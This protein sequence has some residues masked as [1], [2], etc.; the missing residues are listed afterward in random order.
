MEFDAIADTSPFT[1]RGLLGKFKVIGAKWEIWHFSTIASSDNESG[2]GNSQRL[3]SELKPM[4]ERV[5]PSEIKDMSSLLQRDL[6]DSRVA[7]ELIP[8]LLQNQSHIGFFPAILCALMP[9]QFLSSETEGSAAVPYP[10]G[11]ITETNKRSYGD[12]WNISV[13]PG[14]DNKPTAF[15]ELTIHPSKADLI[16]LDGQHRANAFRFLTKGFATN[17]NEI[18]SHFYKNIKAPESFASELPV[19][20]IWFEKVKE[21]EIDP[22]LISRRLFVDVNT[23]AKPVHESRNILLD[24]GT[25]SCVSTSIFYSMLAQKSFSADELSLLHA[26]FDCNNELTRSKLS[27]FSPSIIEYAFR[28]FA[29]GRTDL[30]NLDVK[31]ERDVSKF[32]QNRERLK[33]FFRHLDSATR[34]RLDTEIV[35]TD[36]I[37]RN[38]FRDTGATFASELL[39]KFKLAVLMIQSTT[40]LKNEIQNSAWVNT[41]HS[42]VWEKAYCGGE[43]LFSSFVGSQ[44][45]AISDGAYANAIKE[46]ESKF[47]SI[48]TD[49]A[50][51]LHTSAAESQRIQTL[52]ATFLSKASI[53]GLLMSLSKVAWKTGWVFNSNE[54][55]GQSKTLRAVDLCLS[56]LNVLTFDQ[57]ITVLT[58]FKLGAIG[59]ELNPKLWPQMRNLYLRVIQDVNAKITPSPKFDFQWFKGKFEKSPDYAFVV[60]K[61]RSLERAYK[62]ING[63]VNPPQSE[64]SNFYQEAIKELE[65][66]LNKAGLSSI[67]P[68]DYKWSNSVA[69]VSPSSNSDVED[70]EM[71]DGHEADVGSEEVDIEEDVENGES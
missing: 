25:P 16:V 56:H 24:D 47:L 44:D 58:D 14:K 18:H 10:A 21:E 1:I 20:I 63:N 54:S 5:T 67:I 60:N 55:N 11:Q 66:V 3:L 23:N 64:I 12:Y 22:K 57:W 17:P 52:Y 7:N 26:S 65:V 19:T 8:Y 13:Y 34:N 70:G 59:T 40:K 61:V 51:S 43:G 62:N 9:K 2:A 49:L 69:V 33:R 45:P 41:T 36:V 15:S 48:R 42:A 53:T 50:A 32:W 31:V 29:L 39:S 37:F 35:L 6:D 38:A 46:V 4:R 71:K 27:L 30:D 28:C 68:E